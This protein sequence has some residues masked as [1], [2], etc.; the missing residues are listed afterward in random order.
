MPIHIKFEGPGAFDR[1]INEID[2]D[3]IKLTN[4]GSADFSNVEGAIK[5]DVNV[6]GE[7]LVDWGG[8]LIKLSDVI[9]KIDSFVIKLTQ[10]PPTTITTAAAVGG[11]PPDPQADFLTLDADMKM[12]G[13]DLKTAGTDFI[14]LD[15]APDLA[16]FNADK[17]K[18]GQD[19]AKVS[20][21]ASNTGADFIKL[22]SDLVTIAGGTSSAEIKADLTTFGGDLGKIG[23]AFDTVAVDFMKLSQDFIAAGGGGGT[24][25]GTSLVANAS[26]TE[27]PPTGTF[28]ADFFK[29]EHDFRLLNQT[30]AGSAD[31]AFKLI[32]AIVDQSGKPDPLVD[33]VEQVLSTNGGEHHG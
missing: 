25:T 2:A 16:T 18:F 24:V 4:A 32:D 12:T 33:L 23:A 17:I 10:P 14:K 22:G 15:T 6:I 8:G 21:D 29:L 9:A 31:D 28:G 1:A 19:L 20:L 30:I 3:F 11:G 7:T 27:K 26:L 5:H 13:T